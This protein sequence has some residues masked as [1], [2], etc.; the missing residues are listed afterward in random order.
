MGN[1]AATNRGTPPTP[2]RELPGSSA[3]APRSTVAVITPRQRGTPHARPFSVPISGW[4][5]GHALIQ[6]LSA[7]GRE[8]D[9]APLPLAAERHL[10]GDSARGPTGPEPPSCDTPRA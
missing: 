10:Q 5:S 8:A 1:S 6:V 2:R 9:R 4:V 3:R 7:G